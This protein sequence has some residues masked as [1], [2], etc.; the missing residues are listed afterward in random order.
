MVTHF[1]WVTWAIRSHR[2]FLVS[3]LSD[4]LTLLT[5]ILAKKFDLIAYSLICHE[6]P[7]QF[8]NGH[9]F[10]MS[11]LSD[12]LTVA[13]FSHL[14]WVIWGNRSQSL[15]WFEWNEQK[16]KWVNSQPGNTCVL[17]TV[18]ILGLFLPLPTTPCPYSS[19]LLFNTPIAVTPTG[20]QMG[21][22]GESAIKSPCQT[23][24]W[25]FAWVV[26]WHPALY[27]YYSIPYTHHK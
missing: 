8:A 2:S 14:S 3:V 5:K 7:E 24:S 16:S 23:P 20:N 10:D 18:K 25:V 11:D 9:S 21:G 22:G 17:I 13:H 19:V 4:S 1:W 26:V 27:I 12:L 6:R 15:I